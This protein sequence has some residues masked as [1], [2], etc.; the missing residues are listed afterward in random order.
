MP[1]A[2]LLF[3]L[4][5]LCAL[6]HAENFDP[7][8]PGP[9]AVETGSYKLPPAIDPEVLASMPTELWARVFWPQQM[10]GPR[11][12]VFFLHGN[13]PTCAAPGVIPGTHGGDN[14]EYTYK[15]TCPAG[16]IPTPNHEGYNYAASHLASFGYIVVSVNANRGITCGDA[17]PGDYALNLARG[18]LL[19]KH[20]AQWKSWANGEKIPSTLGSSEAFASH[21]DFSRVGLVG[22]S[23]GGEGVRAAYAYSQDPSAP[24][25]K[26]MPELRIRGIFEIGATDGQTNLTLNA[27]GT[28]WN[29]L[30]PLCDG[31]VPELDGRFPF[32]RM[33][34]SKKEAYPS[35][36]SLFLVWGAN[37]NYFNTE[38]QGNDAARCPGQKRIHGPGP[39]SE[40]QQNIGKASIT[41]FFR[42]NIPAKGEMPSPNLFDPAE[43]LPNS[44]KSITR[45]DRDFLPTADY[46]RFF[47][48]ETF[49]GL[50]PVQPQYRTQG[51]E[52][53]REL[54][55]PNSLRIQWKKGGPE[56]YFDLTWNWAFGEIPIN[57]IDSLNF[58]L[59]LSAMPSYGTSPIADF[60]I[61]LI[62]ES[63]EATEAVPISQFASLVTPPLEIR[64]FQTVRIPLSRFALR[65]RDI[66]SIKGLRLLFPDGEGTIFVT[67]FHFRGD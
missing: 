34:R 64:L 21:V 49:D 33:W 3:L 57:K 38:W 1:L 17:Q 53:R 5:T 13:H 36:K 7:L 61:Q 4:S 45:I 51:V 26:L 23:R 19:L 67:G 43:P 22:H 44:L 55:T 39:W 12:I 52:A 16:M 41:A 58:R 30:I 59:G 25:R 11:P 66:S 46:R 63:G 60:K 50:T 27:E 8:V 20:M 18:R 37:H 62:D 48:I 35:P 2:V 9:F 42:A 10:Q 6:G 28:A 14:C 40:A 24:W 65:S 56:S 47:P 15:G 29:Q 32:E 54:S 31:D